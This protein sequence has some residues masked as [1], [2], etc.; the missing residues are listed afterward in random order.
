MNETGRRIREQYADTG[1]FTD[2]VFAATA[3]LVFCNDSCYQS[4]K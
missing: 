3:L 4:G 2:L 1:G